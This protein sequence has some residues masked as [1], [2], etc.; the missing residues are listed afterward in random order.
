M[1]EHISHIYDKSFKK[2]LTLSSKAVIN[3]INGLFGTSYPTNSNI[4]YNWTEFVDDKLRRTLADTI[5]TINGKHSYHLEAQMESDDDIVFRVFEYGYRNASLNRTTSKGLYCLKFPEPKIIYLYSSGKIPDTYTL[6][7]DFGIQGVFNY[8]VSTFN[9]FK[10]SIEEINQKKLIILIPF[11]LLK[12]RKLLEKNRSPENLTALQKLI[13]NDILDNIETNIGCGNISVSDGYRLL[14][15]TKVLYDE[16]YSHYEEM[17]ELNKMT[18]KALI[19]KYD[20]MEKAMEEREAMLQ[21]KIRT[22]M[23]QE[24]LINELDKALKE[25]QHT[26]IEKENTLQEKDNALQEKDNA[27]QEKD[28]ALQEKDNAL[29]EK[30]NALQEKDNALLESHLEIARLKAEI[31]KLKQR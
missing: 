2:I 19:L 22:L 11:Q 5:L 26:L 29:Q 23:E 10:T 4:T 17:E 16:I 28:N 3:M 6:Q 30:D 27:L 14:D 1:T 15:L 21:E 8:V 25:S 12:L 7:L 9:F 24:N 31:E 13:Q 20:I 18:D